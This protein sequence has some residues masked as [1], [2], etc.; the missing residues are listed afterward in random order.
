MNRRGLRRAGR[1]LA[2]PVAVVGLA[3]CGGSSAPK[4]SSSAFISKC[5]SDKNLTAAIK[6]IPGASGKL[7]SL[8]HCVQNKLV[9]GGFG[10]KTT[11]DNSAQVRNAGRAAGLACAEQILA[12]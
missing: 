6:Q 2:V 9:A 7:G 8:C 11:D 4:I 1:L 10:D 3:A 5:T 12:R